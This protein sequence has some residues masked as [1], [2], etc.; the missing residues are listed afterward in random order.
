MRRE[1]KLN[2]PAIKAIKRLYK[3]FLIRFITIVR[4]RLIR[5]IVTTGK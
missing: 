3:N 2:S 1:G 4:T 5:S